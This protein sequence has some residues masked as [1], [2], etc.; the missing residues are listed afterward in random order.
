MNKLLLSLCAAALTFPAA[1]AGSFDITFGDKNVWDNV[2]DYTS[3]K[4]S[5]TLF[6]GAK[7]TINKFNNN[8]NNWSYIRGGAKNSTTV[9]N[10]YSASAIAEEVL[11][12]TINVDKIANGSV[13]YAKLY[14]SDDATFNDSDDIYTYSGDLTATGQWTI[15]ITEPA[16]N[17]YYKLEFS[18]T[19][20]ATKTNGVLDISK[21]TFE[22]KAEGEVIVEAPTI[23]GE[24]D[25]IDS[26]EVTISVPE[27]CSVRYTT[28]NSNPTDQSSLYSAPFTI[29]ESC[30]VKAVAFDAQGN[31]SKVVAKEFTAAIAPKSIAETILLADN[32][33]AIINY[34]L[35]V[36]FVNA[37]NVFA[38]DEAGD[39]IQIYNDNNLKAGDIIPAGWKGQYTYYKRANATY[40]IHEIQNATL[41]EVTENK[42]FVADVKNYDDITVYDANSIFIL[43]NVVF[44]EAPSAE[45]STDIFATLNGKNIKLF[46]NY[47]IESVPA[48]KYNVTILV[49]LYKD[50]PSLYVIGY[51][52]IATPTF[53][54]FAELK[55]AELED[56]N[57]VIYDGEIY[58]LAST[59]NE[60]VTGAMSTRATGKDLMIFALDADGTPISIVAKNAEN[61]IAAGTKLAGQL[62]LSANHLSGAA[63]GNM[64]E[65]VVVAD[66]ADIQALT[67]STFD[68]E[69][70]QFTLGTDNFADHHGK[71]VSIKHA[72]IYYGFQIQNGMEDWLTVSYY[73][74]YTADE[75][76]TKGNYDME[77]F[78][79]TDATVS[80]WDV[81]GIIFNN[82]FGM[83][84]EML[85]TKATPCVTEHSA[86]ITDALNNATG[87][88][89]V[90]ISGSEGIDYNTTIYYRVEEEGAAEPSMLADDNILKTG[91][92]EGYTALEEPSHEIIIE[93][94]H[95]RNVTVKAYACTRNHVINEADPVSFV[96]TAVETIEA[97]DNEAAEY[98][99]LQGVRVENPT[100]GIYMVRRA[101]KV[102]KEVVR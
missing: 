83:G 74:A 13:T 4:T 54:N 47:G 31:A 87:N 35:H 64:D 27:G 62:N 41:P 1:N 11:K 3:T 24:T 12:V 53:N 69:S 58:V 102:A 34:D 88:H 39:F 100:P 97:A 70:K 79:P 5:K 71:H 61:T 48:G 16:Q 29:T 6:G 21:F 44:E 85:I 14:V 36:G 49:Q 86:I 96:M 33:N 10:I 20:S 57:E 37:R 9:P 101:G 32:T 43:E 67:A 89:T 93:N 73:D 15:N 52:K 80:F 78:G 28:D 56:G 30:T 23:N 7:W 76:L 46:N 2:Q 82:P 90:T 84:R 77:E 50:E 99:N 60:A 42:E 18:C 8:N 68:I 75:I 98:Y 59:D 45:A 63:T 65:F 95:A 55:A 94:S 92:L 51:E 38:R 19:N 22:T 66:A 26:A 40:G 25:F 81:E 91:L 72:E 17:K